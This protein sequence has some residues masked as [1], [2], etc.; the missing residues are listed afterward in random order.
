MSS[1]SPSAASTTTTATPLPP[2]TNE[3]TNLLLLE[4]INLSSPSPEEM[5]SFYVKTCGFVE[6]QQKN[7]AKTGRTIWIDIGRS[8]QIHLPFADKPQR[9]YGKILIAH[10]SPP[11]PYGTTQTD[12]CGNVVQFVR[13]QRVGII[14]IEVEVDEAVLP[15]IVQYYRQYF[16]ATISDDGLLRIGSSQF[17]RFVPMKSPPLPYTGWHV[18]LYIT[19]FSGTYSRLAHSSSHSPDTLV[20]HQ[21]RFSDKCKTLEEAVAGHQFRARDF[22]S[23]NV[24]GN[25]VGEKEVVYQMEHEVRSIA[26]PAFGRLI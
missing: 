16:Q 5:S 23:E 1:P 9:I 10:P 25:N 11:F 6:N 17:I 26:H 21:H 8:S 14:G 13:G 2:P 3:V 19:D 20:F 18:A 7:E 24:G 22:P 4:H 15:A 12:P